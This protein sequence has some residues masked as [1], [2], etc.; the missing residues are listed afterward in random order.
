MTG[1]P[2]TFI[3]VAGINMLQPS[4]E[5]SMRQSMKNAMALAYEKGFQSIAFPLIG[6]RMGWLQTRASQGYHGG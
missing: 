4:S 6:S 1:L 5:W 3:H 2:V